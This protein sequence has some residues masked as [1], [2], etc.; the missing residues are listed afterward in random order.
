MPSYSWAELLPEAPSVM[1]PS[2][3]VTT[4]EPQAPSTT[5]LAEVSPPPN[6][7][8]PADAIS[9]GQ[10]TPSAPV[11]TSSPDSSSEP[12]HKRD[13]PVSESSTSSTVHSTGSDSNNHSSNDSL[14]QHTTDSLYNTDASEASQPNPVTLSHSVSAPPNDSQ[15]LSHVP[16]SH[17]S[18]VSSSSNL[19]HSVQI[20]RSPSSSAVPLISSQSLTV[21]PPAPPT[22]GE[23]IYRTIMNRL[24]ALETNTSLYAR[25]VEEHAAGVR[26]VLRRLS[27]D[28][29]RLEGIVRQHPC[30]SAI[31]IR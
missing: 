16:S 6:P 20:T 14:R 18:V 17:A 10:D 19:S 8:T 13:T 7:A 3:P 2:P 31:F 25:F 21:T 15:Q 9:A 1:A 24:T 27:E 30:I 5:T 23:S 22:S 11:T 26:E 12:A 29:G 28:I 4:D